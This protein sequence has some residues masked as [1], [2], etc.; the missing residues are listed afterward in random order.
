MQDA[1]PAPASGP[2]AASRP[3]E[4]AGAEAAKERD[5][6]AA[7]PG[8]NGTPLVSLTG[9]IPAEKLRVAAAMA[10]SAAAVCAY[11]WART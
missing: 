3:A 1:S 11:I 4:A 6:P 10:L 7:T 9:A 8:A 2:A 5:K